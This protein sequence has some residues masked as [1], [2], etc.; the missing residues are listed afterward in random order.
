MRSRSGAP[1]A[2]ISP[3]QV[4]TIS[5]DRQETIRFNNELVEPQTLVTRLMELK[6]A[7]PDAG[8]VRQVARIDQRCAVE[9][10]KEQAEQID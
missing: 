1:N 7:N 10:G 9:T 2:P 5:I 8:E 4:Q 3:A 6:R